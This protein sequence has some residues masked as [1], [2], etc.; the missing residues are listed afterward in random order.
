[1]RIRRKELERAAQLATQR[2]SLQAMTQAL[3]PGLELSGFHGQY[4][5]MLNEFAHRRVKKMIISVPPQHG[6]ST[7]ASELLPAYLLGLDPGL[8]I[9]IGSYGFSLARRFGAAVQRI[10]DDPKYRELFPDTKLKGRVGQDPE[11]ESTS[12]VSS[13]TASRTAEQIDTIGADG[14]LRL[15]GR[16]GALT[17]CRVDVMIMDDLYKDMAE[18]NSPIVRQS[19]WEWYTSVVRTRLSNYSREIII[20]TRW[21]N[22]DL[23]GQIQK[24]E[25]VIQISS[26]EQLADVGDD[27]WVHINFE[28][29]KQG[30]P[31]EID[32]R[33]HGEPLWPS[34]HSIEL[35]ESKRRLDPMVFEA[36][37][38]GNPT[39]V[40]GLLYPEFQTYS[41]LPDNPIKVANYTDTAD[42]GAD[43]LCSVC[44]VVSSERLIYITDVIYTDQSM[45]VT[46]SL[47]AKMLER[48]NTRVAYV[49]S[50]NGGRGFARAV[51]RLLSSSGCTIES[52]HQS[53]SKESRILTNAPTVASK[54]LMPEG[55]SSRWSEFARDLNLFRRSIAANAHDD[56]PDVLT[57]IVERELFD[58]G[59]KI[60]K[61][62][63]RS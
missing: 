39:A 17:G 51:G 10:M 54:I 12:K 2:A 14:G 9:C 60:Q 16:Q 28:A 34:R 59:A 15:V 35:L 46:E 22:E 19:A 62:R 5:E 40:T 41:M 57:G 43:F 20:F 29:I 32:P 26:F 36:L 58:T 13:R 63:F 45:E 38:Q 33:R 52:F 50:N 49:E 56:A 37:Y 3:N 8:R 48:Q 18:A 7:A 44:Y 6:K 21:H 42:T 4:Y 30:P 23:V 53:G 11:Q 24:T 25:K 31:T 27:C 47:V 1:M 55:W 61:I